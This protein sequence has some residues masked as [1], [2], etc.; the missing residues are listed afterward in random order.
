VRKK[1]PTSTNSASSVDS[2]SSPPPLRSATHV[3]FEEPAAER[4]RGFGLTNVIHDSDRLAV[5]P[6]RL[7]IPEHVRARKAWFHVDEPW[8]H[9]YT[10]DVRWEAPVVVWVSQCL[11]ER[12]S[13]WKTCRWLQG[14]G[15][16]RRDV[17]I[18]DVPPRPPSPRAK[19]PRVEPF[20]CGGSVFYQSDDALRAHL[21]AARPWPHERY[22]QAVKLWEQYVSADPR[23]FARSCL[24]G[25]PGFPELGPLWA[26]LSRFFPRMSAERTLRLSPYDELLLHALSAQWQA[27][28][29]AYINVV[30]QRSEFCACVGD[31]TMMGRLAIWADH[32]ANSA[33]ER[34]PDPQSPAEE[35][36]MTSSVYR[37][38]E[39][40]IEL[41]AGLPEL[42]DAPRLPVGGAEAYALEAPW[43]LLD[44]GRLVRM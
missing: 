36:P 26:F 14:L 20:D 21:V 25:V 30:H 22:D 6:S 2:V 32:D 5:G 9:I 19:A 39:R 18:L 33:V 43:V 41:R 27:A 4:L 44:D 34:A 1:S 40:G 16:P 37:L 23:R 28:V 42:A 8:D 15:I 3:A 31:L 10:V 17:L 24:R 11:H 29:K 35:Y 7:D 12:L 13:L 38:T